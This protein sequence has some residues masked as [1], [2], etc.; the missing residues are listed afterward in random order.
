[1]RSLIFTGDGLGEPSKMI[2]HYQ[3][4]LVITFWLFQGKKSKTNSRLWHSS[5]PPQ[6]S[7]CKYAYFNKSSKETAGRKLTNSNEFSVIIW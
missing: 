4:I 7:Q 3:N 2:G 1:M 5:R 6:I